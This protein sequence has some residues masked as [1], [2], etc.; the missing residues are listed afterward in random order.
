MLSF[1][2]YPFFQPDPDGRFGNISKEGFVANL[3]TV[4][5]AALG[6]SIPFWVAIRVVPIPFGVAGGVVAQYD[7]SEAQLRWQAFTALA[8][9]AKGIIYFTCGSRIIH[10]SPCQ[11]VSLFSRC[12]MRADLWGSDWAMGT[13]DGAGMV[14]MK[15][16]TSNHAP[17]PHYYQ[18]Q[19]I[20]SV[21]R[22]FGT[23]LLNATSTG[24]YRMQSGDDAVAKLAGCAVTNITMRQGCLGG[25]CVAW[26]LVVG[27]FRL[28]DAR[29]ALLVVNQDDRHTV[30]PSFNGTAIKAWQEVDG[31]TGAAATV[32]S[33]A[34]QL[35]GLALAL[36]P[37]QG[38]LLLAAGGA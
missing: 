26:S 30:V 19:R 38:R 10:P 34:P 21:L 3:A 1:D 24:V 28:A 9:G 11:P 12:L 18:A 7:P 14:E 29:T 31:S 22:V 27:Q 2:H 13:F 37:G 5:R 33:D 4:R 35:R 32:Q 15:G 36:A 17:G 6:A 8:Y 25:A 20:N 23:L 16:N